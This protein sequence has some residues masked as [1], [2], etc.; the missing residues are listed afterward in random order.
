MVQ[1]FVETGHVL[2]CCVTSTREAGTKRTTYQK[3]VHMSLNIPLWWE[4]EKI[5]L[6]RRAS[7]C[8]PAVLSFGKRFLNKEDIA[9]KRVLE[10]G[11]RNVNGSLREYIE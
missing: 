4:L 8:N 1:R 3:D 7:M 9:G 2:Q 11:A 5:R 6:E 10:I